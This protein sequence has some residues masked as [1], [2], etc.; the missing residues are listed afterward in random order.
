MYENTTLVDPNELCT[1][2]WNPKWQC[3]CNSTLDIASWRES[4]K[5]DI[6]TF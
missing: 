4:I 6:Y 3:L 5:S 1:M 2:C